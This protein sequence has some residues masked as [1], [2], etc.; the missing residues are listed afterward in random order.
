MNTHKN[1]CFEISAQN[2]KA[3]SYNYDRMIAKAFLTLRGFVQPAAG[4]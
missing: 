4:C 2:E 3:L 1:L